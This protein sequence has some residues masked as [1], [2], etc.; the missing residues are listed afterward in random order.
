MGQY[1][2]VAGGLED[3]QIGGPVGF[4]GRTDF[5]LGEVSLCIFVDGEDV[6]GVGPPTSE[7]DGL[8]V[9]GLSFWPVLVV[10]GEEER[11]LGVVGGV[12]EVE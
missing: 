1:S 2:V 7:V 9:I 10:E 11:L 3:P 8:Q 12:E 5:V 4:V 6:V